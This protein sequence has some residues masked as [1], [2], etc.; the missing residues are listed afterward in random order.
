MN[1]IQIFIQGTADFGR[2]NE[3]FQ[4]LSQT[5]TNAFSAITN[6][7]KGFG[8]LAEVFA[9]GE[10]IK[11]ANEFSNEWIKS[12]KSMAQLEAAL[13]STGQAGAK[14]RQELEEQRKAIS[15]ATGVEEDQLVVVQRHLVQYKASQEQIM[16]LTKLS[17]DLA[18]SQ[19]I[20]SASAATTLARA[21]GG[22]EVQL[23]GVRLEIDRTLPKYQQVKQL[24]E[25]LT[26]QVGGQQRA[27][28]L[29]AGSAIQEFNNKLE[30]TKKGSGGVWTAIKENTLEGLAIEKNA[31][32]KA[33]SAMLPAGITERSSKD[34]ARLKA[35]WDEVFMGKKPPDDTNAGGANAVELHNR[36]MQSLALGEVASEAA[37]QSVSD[38][39][40]NS[41]SQASNEMA[42]ARGKK[43]LAEYLNARQRLIDQAARDEQL[44]IMK[45]LDAAEN[46]LLEKRKE[47]DVVEQ[48]GTDQQIQKITAEYLKVKAERD[49][50]VANLSVA[51]DNAVKNNLSLD[52]SRGPT[53]FREG[54]QQ[55]WG[56]A[57][58][59]LGNVYKNLADT[60]HNTVGAAIDGVSKGI[61]GLI[62]GT[63]TW[64]QALRNIG[65]SVLSIVID[66]IVKMFAA[67]VTG[68]GLK[69]A[70]VIAAKEAETAADLMKQAA[71][72]PGKL[73]DMLA[74]AVGEG[75]WAAAA[76][77]GAAVAALGLGVAAA[78]GAFA[79]GGRPEPGKIALVGERGPELWV[80]DVAGTILPAHVTSDIRSGR[81]SRNSLSNRSRAERPQV[82][83]T[84]VWLDQGQM[85]KHILEN[86]EG[87]HAILNVV[88]KN[89]HLIM[90][91]G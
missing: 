65:T 41:V 70:A 77:I 67:W 76:L 73:I 91:N 79:E 51:K 12:A 36:R 45:A 74:T 78:E 15:A 66:G 75:G 21:L 9:V 31:I 1:P 81:G 47:L 58:N 10:L 23:R 63:E 62:T 34:F 13:R 40:V 89:S 14:Y 60:I 29:A 80:P 2:I 87:E 83:H 43:S 8:L 42:Y 19:G 4:K 28:F 24:I 84:H 90:R 85:R 17:L 46:D 55:G 22:E 71:T 38:L 27:A 53:T 64:G 54:I 88:G 72:L 3:E 30:E 57:V 7:S 48:S 33:L 32:S 26:A 56:G 59:D 25:Q 50:L 86:P 20:D 16:E 69:S 18:A 37:S 44:P 82:F 52:Q 5:S 68:E 6:L 49:K 35:Y 61:T 39:S 11:T